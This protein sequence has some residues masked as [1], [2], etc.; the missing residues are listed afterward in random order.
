MV[1]ESSCNCCFA[2][3]TRRQ[4]IRLL[5]AKAILYAPQL[6]WSSFFT[7]W[8]GIEFFLCGCVCVFVYYIVLTDWRISFPSSVLGLVGIVKNY[9][10]QSTKELIFFKRTRIEAAVNASSVNRALGTKWNLSSDAAS[11]SPPLLPY[12]HLWC[13]GGHFPPHRKQ[14]AKKWKSNNNTA[15]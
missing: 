1:T 12:Y 5:T 2:G 10:W 3:T 13:S 7:E 15:M 9:L 6:H 8:K 11:V 4:T 14:C